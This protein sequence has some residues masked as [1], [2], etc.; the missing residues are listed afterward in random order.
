M[1]DPKITGE[2]VRRIVRRQ[3]LE[4]KDMEAWLLDQPDRTD[5]F[6]MWTML[7][8]RAWINGKRGAWVIQSRTDNR[9]DIV[10]RLIDGA[11]EEIIA[12]PNQDQT[13]AAANRRTVG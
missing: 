12:K 5:L 8:V 10:S 11:V 4:I 3:A 7:V 1:N 6:N 9:D 13:S 2:I